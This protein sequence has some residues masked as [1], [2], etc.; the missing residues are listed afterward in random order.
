MEE[1]QQTER[2]P[3]ELEAEFYSKKLNLSYSGL[4][5]MMYSPSLYY[6]HYVLQQREEKLDTYLIDGKLIHCLLL[7]D[8]SFDKEFILS[9]ATLPTGNTKLVIDKVFVNSEERRKTEDPY[10]DLSSYAEE[11]LQ[12]L[13]EINLHQ[14]LK[15]DQQR[16]D[17]IITEESKNYF[18]FLKIKGD[19]NLID[20][21]TLQR[22]NEAVDAVRGDT[23]A[24]N[25]LGLVKHEM[26]N[27]DIFNEIPMEA[28]LDGH[29]FSIKG[30]IDNIKVDYVAK[31]V[32][33]NDLKTTGKTISDF[34]ETIEFY[35]YWIQAAIY[36]RLVRDNFKDLMRSEPDWKIVFHF[37]V[38]DKY[39]Q[40]YSF[41]VS[42]ITMMNWDSQLET[43]FIE[44]KWHYTEKSYK[45]PYRFA[46]SPVIL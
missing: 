43:K 6:R 26:D 36:Q 29:P 44:F 27:I 28:E 46:I 22:C 14:S 4:S 23:T 7:D 8:G 13:K 33:I 37:I 20:T 15:T 9:P 17:K 11:A 35:N 19:K 45:L 25:L 38:I 34:E 18:N 10:R 12:V 39:N 24:S 21:E 5:K 32:Y 42:T 2:T 30:I 31:T 41:E 3:K 16:L 40:I 1:L